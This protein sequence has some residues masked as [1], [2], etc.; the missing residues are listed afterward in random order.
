[1]KDF[2]LITKT[3]TKSP[4]DI[5]KLLQE[6][7]HISLQ[8]CYESLSESLKNRAEELLPEMFNLAPYGD[9][10]AM[11]EEPQDMLQFLIEEAAQPK[12][13]VVQFLDVRKQDDQ[14]LE[15]M[16]Y[17]TAVDDG[18]ILKGFVFIGLSGTI[19]HAFAQI[20]N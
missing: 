10:N 15:L 9:Y 20:H 2:D 12:N 18:D 1:M 17:N 5:D 14:L 16:A 8:D 3:E 7:L 11:M 19:R 4:E 6:H 13:W